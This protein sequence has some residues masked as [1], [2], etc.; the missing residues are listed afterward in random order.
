MTDLETSLVNRQVWAEDWCKTMSQNVS[1]HPSVKE[2]ISLSATVTGHLEISCVT[3]RF[4]THTLT[5]DHNLVPFEHSQRNHNFPII[6]YQSKNR[7]NNAPRKLIRRGKCS[8]S[9]TSL[10][11]QSSN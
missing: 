7:K 5:I 11:H 3:W 6:D 2:R 1:T 10:D 4:K 9:P 8:S